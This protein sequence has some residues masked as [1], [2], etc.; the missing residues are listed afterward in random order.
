M[1]KKNFSRQRK[2][3]V[4]NSISDGDIKIVKTTKGISVSIGVVFKIWTRRYIPRPDGTVYSPSLYSWLEA[5]IETYL[6]AQKHG[7]ELFSEESD[8]TYNDILRDMKMY[9]MANVLHPSYVFADGSYADKCTNDY[10]SWITSKIEEM[11]EST[12]EGIISE[13]KTETEADKTDEEYINAQEAAKVMA[14]ENIN[15]ASKEDI[16]AMSS[17]IQKNMQN[18]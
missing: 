4:I 1:S 18:I 12:S 8:L 15:R 9:L 11:E 10:V 17:V 5:Y 3:E 7:E 6:H 14:S 2:A 13:E 16:A